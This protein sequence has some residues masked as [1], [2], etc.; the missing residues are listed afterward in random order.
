MLSISFTPS[1]NSGSSSSEPPRAFVHLAHLAQRKITGIREIR[2]L[3]REV[4]S[5][6]KAL[7]RSRNRDAIKMLVTL[8]AEQ[9]E[10]NN[11][12]FLWALRKSRIEMRR[13]R[14]LPSAVL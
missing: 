10:N 11:R 2:D 14:T 4:K 6:H 12:K 5:A 3:L 7:V 13:A 1:I 9:E 8:E